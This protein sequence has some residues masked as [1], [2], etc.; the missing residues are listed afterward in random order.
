MANLTI[1][2][3]AAVLSAADDDLLLIWRNANG[4]TRSITKADFFDGLLTGDGTITGGGIL[5]TGGFTLTVPA[6]GTASLLGAAQAYSALKTFNAGITFGDETLSE[7]DED[8]WTPADG[9]GAGLTFTGV[10]ARYTRFGR[11]CW[12]EFSF[13]YP[14]TADGSTATVS[15]LPFL[16]L[17]L[18]GSTYG[19]GFLYTT[20]LGVDV[21]LHMNGADEFVFVKTDGTAL[22]NAEASLSLFRGVLTFAANP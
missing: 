9:S 21:K 2:E 12:A 4:D 1:N 19:G 7:Y 6:T 20:N 14:S 10:S 13:S 11:L 17:L 3:I 16:A 15:G 5:A 18:A 22:T 8:V